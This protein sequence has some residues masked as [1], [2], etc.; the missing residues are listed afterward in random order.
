[1]GRDENGRR[2]TVTF[3]SSVSGIHW[4]DWGT[5]EELSAWVE[6]CWRRK[7]E[8][9]CSGSLFG[10]LWQ[11]FNGAAVHF[12]MEKRRHGEDGEEEEIW[13]ERKRR[14]E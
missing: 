13:G 10:L 1:M 11:V 8:D 2:F 7:E 4:E 6:T 9:E 5:G 3:V 12:G 14:D